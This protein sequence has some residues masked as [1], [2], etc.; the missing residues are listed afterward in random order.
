MSHG[1]WSGDIDYFAFVSG[2]VDILMRGY[3][4]AWREGALKCGVLPTERTTEEDNRLAREITAD[5]GRVR[6][7]GDFIK[8]H[9]RALG[10]KYETI[11]N[12][13]ELWANRYQSVV[14]LAQVTA[15]SDQKF[16]WRMG[17]TEEHCSDCAS[18]SGKVYRG[19]VWSK[20]GALP[21]SGGLE[22]GGFRCDCSLEATKAP[23][24]S[25]HPHSPSGGM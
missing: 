25:G 24:T 21:R 9:T 20:W 13:A 10:Y 12:R 6:P 23:A 19:S 2:L 5:Q 11:T 4:Q 1:L 7:Y 8:L 22:C 3:E 18:Y 16:L 15:C 17:Q 14:A